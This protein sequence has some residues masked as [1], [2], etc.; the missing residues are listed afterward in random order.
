MTQDCCTPDG[1]LSHP[2]AAAIHRHTQRARGDDTDDQGS[3]TSNEANRCYTAAT[4]THIIAD[5][6]PTEAKQGQPRPHP[7]TPS[8]AD[9]HRSSTNAFTAHHRQSE[10]DAKAEPP[11]AQPMHIAARQCQHE[12]DLRSPKLNQR[13]PNTI[14]AT[15]QWRRT[16]KAKQNHCSPSDATQGT[17]H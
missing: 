5:T 13:S 10:A 2:T 17:E 8:L 3:P 7:R 15:Q 9:V 6:K 1:N 12:A 11:E 14:A 4:T 16:R